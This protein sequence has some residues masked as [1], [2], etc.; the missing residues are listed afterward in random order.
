MVEFDKNPDII[1][2]SLFCH[3]FNNDSLV[4][5]LSWMK[6][7]ATIGFFINDLH[8][9]KLAY[10]LIKWLTKFFLNLI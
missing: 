6:E 2:S 1:F 10:W 5:Q 3:H 4:K 8:R 9:H 7:N